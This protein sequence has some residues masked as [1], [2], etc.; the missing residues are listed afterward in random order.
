MN[1]PFLCVFVTFI[2]NYVS[3]VPVALAMHQQVG[4][5]DN[6]HPRDQQ[7]K[8]SGWGRRAL[9]AHMNGF[10]VAPAF[11]AAVLIGHLANINP[12]WLSLLSLIFVAS[13]LVYI[14]LY[15]GNV[16]TLRSAVWA[17]GMAC[18]AAIFVLAIA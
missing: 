1:I 5:Y 15:L 6:Q 14:G 16:S 13:R 10:E 8:L 2:L 18:I 11:A 17:L 9:G 7:A 3:K 12:H 4:G